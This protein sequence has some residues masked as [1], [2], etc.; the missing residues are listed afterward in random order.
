MI[1]SASA[2]APAIG[3]TP[4]GDALDRVGGNHPKGLLASHTGSGSLSGREQAP[5]LA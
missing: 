3:Q 4:W 5:P 2:G 1:P